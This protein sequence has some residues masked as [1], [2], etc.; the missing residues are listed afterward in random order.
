MIIVTGAAGFIGSN[1]VAELNDRGHH[2][3]V[4]VDRLGSDGKWRNIAKRRFSDWIFPEEL[5]RFLG[6]VDRAQAVFHLGA[7]SSTTATDADEIV[8]TN[9]RV[10]T[11][12]WNWCARTA[13]PLVYASSAATYGDG[14][15]GFDDSENEERFEELRPLNLYGWSKHAFDRW[16][17]ARRGAGNAPPF[18]A[19]L[20]FFN[21]YGPNEYHKG[22]M[23][24][25]V[26]K[27]AALIAAGQSI[28]LF[29]SHRPDYADGEQLRDFIYVADCTR[30]MLWLMEARARSGLFNLGTGKARSFKDLMLATGKALGRDVRFDFRDMP[31]AIRPN[32]QYFTEARMEK[33]GRAG[34]NGPF[35]SLEDGVADYVTRFLM[36]DD[37]YR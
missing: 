20:K 35:H 12:L 28:T 23:Q 1:L 8:R 19:G 15:R 14:A 34:F 5:E 2:D 11:L 9:F 33:L 24:S 30:A 25:L 17:L 6:S 32:Y 18:W 26:A 36:K 22:D 16:V 27:N 3:L 29:K 10:S 31:E 21:V 13:T 4:L 37:K 7:N